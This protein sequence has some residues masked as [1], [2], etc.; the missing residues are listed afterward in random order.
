MPYFDPADSDDLALIHPA[1]LRDH[2]E[3]AT[4]AAQVEHDVLS[5]TDYDAAGTT[6]AA[7]GEEADALRR[8]VADVTAHRLRYYEDDDTLT[9]Q[10]HG[11]RSEKRPEGALDKRWPA[12]WRWRLDRFDTADDEGGS[13]G[14]VYVT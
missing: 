8:T 13:G 3:L 4:V 5:Q 12:D 9:S 7:T 1:R 11:G 2:G 14:I 10:S 6:G